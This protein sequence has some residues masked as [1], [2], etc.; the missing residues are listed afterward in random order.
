MSSDAVPSGGMLGMSDEPL[1]LLQVMA[2][3]PFG[4]AEAFFERM[5][6]A[7]ANTGVTQHVAVRGDSARLERLRSTNASI[8][9]HRFGGAI[10]LYT[11]WQLNRLAKRYQPDVT[12]AW[13]SRAAKMAPKRHGVV[14]A[15]L[16]G[17]YNLKYYK[18]CRHLIGNTRDICD[19]LVRQGWPA[20][21]THYLPNFV[22]AK[23]CPPEDRAL[24]DTAD[25]ATVILAV[26]R[27]HRRKGFDVLLA[28]LAQLPRAV[29]WIAGI[30]PEEAELKR[31]AGAL[32][33]AERVRWLGWRQDVG[34]LYAAADVFVCPSRQEPL[35]NV[36]IEAWAHGAP[37]VATQ[38]AGPLSLIEPDVT[39]LLVP[40]DD[41]DAIVT[42]VRALVDDPARAA[43]MCVAG[44]QAYAASFTEQAVVAQYLEFFD[45][46]RR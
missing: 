15:R 8:S 26:G 3:A 28:A 44:K 33:V 6:V 41:A 4:G 16:G 46:V 13:M 34:A 45:Q 10:D 42:A 12:L 7:L 25:D 43:E 2:G 1:R 17:Y 29:L 40:P 20:E 11:P 35:G 32:G 14:A 23:P 9:Q 24:H 22:D 37:V 21:Q 27:L 36:V 39:G 5:V 38:S 31:I 18:G 30:G 19:Y